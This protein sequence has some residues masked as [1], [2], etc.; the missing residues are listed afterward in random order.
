M[1]LYIL[2]PNQTTKDLE[3]ILQYMGAVTGIIFNVTFIWWMD[4]PSRGVQS[5]IKGIGYIV[6]LNVLFLSA[7]FLMSLNITEPGKIEEMLARNVRNNSIPLFVAIGI[8]LIYYPYRRILD[9]KLR[10]I[11]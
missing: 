10:Q 4:W 11:A 7:G 3:V 5:L 2:N 1:L 6:V 9:R 8:Y